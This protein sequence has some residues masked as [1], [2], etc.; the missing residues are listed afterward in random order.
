[1]LVSAFNAFLDE[2]IRYSGR[3]IKRGDIIQFDCHKIAN[4]MIK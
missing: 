3:N 2:S 4:G 1:M